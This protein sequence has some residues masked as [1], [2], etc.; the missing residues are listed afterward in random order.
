V[1]DWKTE[2]DG[3]LAYRHGFYRTSG[4]GTDRKPLDLTLRV[5]DAYKR[6][7]GK[8]LVIHEHI[9]WPVDLATGTADFTSKP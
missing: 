2:V 7:N 3:N 9:S 6:I 1:C 5:T 4:A 8:W